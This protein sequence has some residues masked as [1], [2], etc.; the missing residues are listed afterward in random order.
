MATIMSQ[1]DQLP[2]EVRR[3]IYIFVLSLYEAFEALP[4]RGVLVSDIESS[5]NR[6]LSKVAKYQVSDHKLELI[7]DILGEIKGQKALLGVTRDTSTLERHKALTLLE[8]CGKLEETFD[9]IM[10]SLKAE[11]EVE[12]LEEKGTVAE[13]ARE[14]LGPAVEAIREMAAQRTI[15]TQSVSGEATVGRIG[16]T[17]PVFAGSSGPLR[18]SVSE[19]SEVRQ[20][21]ATSDVSFRERP[22]DSDPSEHYETE[23]VKDEGVEPASGNAELSL[24]QK[25]IME[26]LKRREKVTVG[27]LGLLF[28][29]RVSKKTLQRDLQDLLARRIIQRKGDRRWAVYFL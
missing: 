14:I 5:A 21:G 28:S 11:A 4:E 3:N 29:G 24:R 20:L 9:S 18:Q 23:L 15:E 17:R 16:E 13:A 10:H 27:D 25:A 6:I 26:V 8:E 1:I 22:D 2:L 7:K 12:V 19:A